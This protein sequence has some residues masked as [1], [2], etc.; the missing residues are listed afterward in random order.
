MAGLHWQFDSRMLQQPL[1]A[2]VQSHAPWRTSVIPHVPK[3]E[4]MNQYRAMHYG[5]S[6]HLK[7]RIYA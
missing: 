3:H 1:T 2:D 6:S 4:A 5:H 7:N